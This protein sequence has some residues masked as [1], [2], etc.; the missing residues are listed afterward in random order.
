MKIELIPSRRRG[1]IWLRIKTD[2]M[3]EVS[4]IRKG[5]IYNFDEL[6]IETPNGDKIKLVYKNSKNN[7]RA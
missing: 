6:E 5:T 3:T 2:P 4:P 7:R 1:N